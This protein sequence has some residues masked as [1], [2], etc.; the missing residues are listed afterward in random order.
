MY[1]TN[2]VQSLQMHYNENQNKTKNNGRDKGTYTGHEN[3]I[4]INR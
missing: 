1:Y 2:A 4:A 3:K